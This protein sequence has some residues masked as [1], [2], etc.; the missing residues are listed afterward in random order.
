MQ[1]LGWKSSN[2]HRQRIGAMRLIVRKPECLDDCI[3]EWRLL[4]RATV[5]PAPLMMCTWP[6]AKFRQF[7]GK[8][9]SVQYPRRVWANLN[10]RTNFTQG[11]GLFVYLHVETG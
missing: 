7:V 11:V 1:P 10:S 5:I 4:Q 3:A 8:A 2:Q 9:Q 6:H